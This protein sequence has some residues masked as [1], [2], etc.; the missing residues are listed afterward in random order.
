V[1]NSGPAP[2]GEATAIGGDGNDTIVSDDGFWDVVDC[3]PSNDTVTFDVDLDEI[4]NCEIEN[5]AN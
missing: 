1:G 5:P 4:S 3:G 2:E